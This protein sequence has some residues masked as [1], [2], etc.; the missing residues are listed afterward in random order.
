MMNFLQLKI[1]ESLAGLMSQMNEKQQGIVA[2]MI[3]FYKQQY[4]SLRNLNN[5]ESVSSSIHNEIDKIMDE[6]IRE[7]KVHKVSCSK[8]CSF[9]CYLFTEISDDEATLLTAYSKE[10]GFEIDYD[11]LEKQSV[12]TE[13][14]FQKLRYRTRRCVFLD[15]EGGCSV[16]QHRPMACRKLLSVSDSSKCDTQKRNGEQIA[17]LASVEAEAITAAVLNERETGSIAKMLLKQKNG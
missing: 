3:A 7:E 10:I 2:D 9:C 4:S 15:K 14:D 12:E 8:G 17:K 13:E 16:Y 6:T 5:A 1:S 11:Y